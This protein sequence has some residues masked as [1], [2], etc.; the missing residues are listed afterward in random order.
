MKSCVGQQMPQLYLRGSLCN[1]TMA[2]LTSKQKE[3][4]DTIVNEIINFEDIQRCRYSFK[5][6]LSA[7]IGGDYHDDPESAEQEFRIAVWRAV[8]AAK[9]GWGEIIEGKPSNPPAYDDL[10]DNISK[11]KFYQTWV[12]N[13]LRQMMMENKR[14][15]ITTSS[16]KIIPTW[17]IVKDEIICTLKGAPK[18]INLNSHQIII[19]IDTNLLPSG[20]IKNINE[21]ISKYEKDVF[22]DITDDCIHISSNFELAKEEVK[23]LGCNVIIENE[24][25][26]EAVIK[27]TDTN[28]SFSKIKEY[29]SKR[30][31]FNINN[32]TIQMRSKENINVVEI[33]IATK[34]NTVSTNKDK[35][36]NEPILEMKD[37]NQEQKDPDAIE[38]YRKNL[39]DTSK[40]I[41]EIIINPPDDYIDTYK[42]TKPVQKYIAEYLGI[43]MN[44]CKA[45]YEEMRI[46][47]AEVGLA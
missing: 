38:Y 26:F 9:H 22:V 14:P 10:T 40:K 47:Y 1:V 28:V 34:V 13:Y 44:E 5:R 32:N 37:M 19:A 23:K 16:N 2:N 36:E 6:A 21:I 31:L 15:M 3:E 42:T 41:M 18:R 43:S 20:I 39:S 4:I 24:S 45:A 27:Q 29:L 12:F 8:V 33:K 7:T 17:N 11:K 30:V 25:Y 35:E 46:K